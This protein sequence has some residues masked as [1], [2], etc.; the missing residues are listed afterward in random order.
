MLLMVPATKKKKKND[1]TP[2][3][4]HSNS[5]SFIYIFPIFFII[6]QH[7]NGYGQIS[8]QFLL[9]WLCVTVYICYKKE[10]DKNSKNVKFCDII[11]SIFFSMGYLPV[12]FKNK[13]CVCLQFTENQSGKKRTKIIPSLRQR[14]VILKNV[15]DNYRKTRKSM[16]I[17]IAT[18]F[19]IFF[20]V[21]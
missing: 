15:N 8:Q 17:F 10:N 2:L 12:F 1:L 6:S 5:I 11:F 14:I 3:F 21:L 16:T 18:V 20:I 9:F 4:P 7:L 13:T 19:Q